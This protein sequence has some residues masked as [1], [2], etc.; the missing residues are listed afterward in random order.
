MKWEKYIK[1]EVTK[2]QGDKAHFFS[3]ADGVCVCACMLYLCLLS[4]WKVVC[5]YAKKLG[6]GL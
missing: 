1:L 3:H 6:R 5:V 2:A 4:M